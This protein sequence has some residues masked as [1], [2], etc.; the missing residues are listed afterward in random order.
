MAS[1]VPATASATSAPGLGPR[2]R[3]AACRRYSQMIHRGHYPRWGGGGEAWCSPTSTSM[4]L[5]WYGALPPA[6][7]LPLGAV[8]PPD[9]FVDHAARRVYDHAYDGAGNW[10][11]NTAYAAPLAGKAFVT[12]LRSMREAERFVVARIPLVISIAFDAGE[13]DGAPISSSNGHLLVVVGSRAPA[14]SWSTTPRRPATVAS[15]APTTAASSSA[16]GSTPP[17]ASPTSS[18]TPRT[19]SPARLAA[20][21]VR[22]T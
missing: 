6:A 13:L 20:R 9:P 11:F 8:R 4:V 7:R 15:A 19:R 17:A 16:P 22:L 1:K 2:P 5:G 3:D 21:P 12:R 14:T 10:P 18:A